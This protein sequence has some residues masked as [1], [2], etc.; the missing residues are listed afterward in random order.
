MWVDRSNFRKTKIVNVPLRALDA[1]EITVAI[2]KFGLTANNVSYAVSGDFIGYWKFYPATDNWGKVT[3]WGC[4]NVIESR[5]EDIA[6]GERLYGFFPMSSHTILQPG[7]VQE[8]SFIDVA[9]HRKELPGTGLYSSYRRTQH[10]PDIVQQYET[11]RCLLFPLIATGYVLYDYLV[12]NNFFGAQQVVVGSASSKTGFGLATLLQNDLTV[13]QKVIGV[14][15]ERNAPFVESLKCCDQ[16]VTYGNEADIDPSLPTAYVDMSGDIKLTR[17]LHGHIKN[18]IVESAMVGASHWEDGGK[19]GELPGA[20]PTF[21]F[22]PGQIAKRDK[23]W[24]PGVLM[25]K[26][27]EATL[28]ISAKVNNIIHVEWSQGA[29]AVD[30]SW[31][32][33]LDNK[34]P[35]SVGIM[36]TLLKGQE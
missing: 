16:I 11:E 3:V 18:N 7:K 19:A 2:D 33:L 15:S 36:A 30:Q 24:G 34:V 28:S 17:A 31:H 13:T 25:M 32:N 26:A 21:F 23:E 14:T 20:K 27:M 5:S 1:G 35:G 8:D 9:P 6:V 12:D 10:E 29:D 4:G 22:A